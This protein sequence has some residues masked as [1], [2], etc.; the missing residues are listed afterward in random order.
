[1]VICY[2]SKRQ[3]IQYLIEMSIYVYQNT[4]TGIFQEHYL[5]NPKLETIQTSINS[6]MDK[7]IAIQS[8]NKILHCNGNEWT[9]ATHSMWHRLTWGYTGLTTVFL[10]EKRI[11]VYTYTYDF[12]WCK[13]CIG[14]NLQIIKSITLLS[15]NSM[16]SIDSQLCWFLLTSCIC[17]QA[18]V[19]TD[20]HMWLWREY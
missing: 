20:K 14:H 7:C 9:T 6:R 15:V 2:I 1:M 18:V 8:F 3:L 10:G 17:S 5:L 19:A 11:Y 12:Y 13:E 16:L 4:F